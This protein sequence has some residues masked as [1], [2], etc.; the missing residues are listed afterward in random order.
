M[1]NLPNVSDAP[2]AAA[3]AAPSSNRFTGL[4]GLRAIAVVLVMVYHLFPGMLLGGFIGVDVFF[5]IS[6]FLITS[7]LV[8]ER[9]VRGRISLGRFWIRRA[10]RLVPALVTVVAVCTTIALVLGGDLL[11]GIGKQVLGA[12]TFSYNWIQIAAGSDYFT[13]DTPEL[14]RNFWSL[15][16]EEQFYIVWPFLLVVLMA[17]R[18]TW[19]RVVVVTAAAAGS[20]WWMLQLSLG[21]ADVT[22]MYYG[23]DSHA[24]GLLIGAALAFALARP[25]PGT[26]RP[27]IARSRVLRVVPPAIGLL[28]LAGVLILSGTLHEGDEATF[29]GGLALVSL[30]MVVVIWG[31]VQARSFLGRILDNAP[32]RYIGERSYGLY[33]WHWPLLVLTFA[34]MP[35]EGL[36]TPADYTVSGIIAALLTL[37]AAVLSYRFIEQPIRRNGFRATL[38]VAVGHLRRGPARAMGTAVAGLAAIALVATTTIAVAAAPTQTSAQDAIQRGEQA[39]A[40]GGDSTLPPA[41]PSPTPV[42]TSTDGTTPDPT[43]SP[44]PT[45]P[46]G[47][48]ITAIGDSVMLA[49]APELQT[50]FPGIYIDA[51]VSRSMFA[52]PDLLRTL[53]ASG[54]LRQTIVIGL[55]T[56]GP[57]RDATL[58]EI[59]EIA[60][61]DRFVVFVNAY[62]PRSWIDGVNATLDNSV[63]THE[64]AAVADWYD[65]VSPLA[66]QVLAGDKIHPGAKGGRLYAQTILS[67]FKDLIRA[68]RQR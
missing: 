8:R 42:P 58:S 5:V 1:S 44:A 38:R 17:V 16:V 14:F 19:L 45:L 11:V 46:T 56:N 39:L 36:P 31:A 6:G 60:G 68:Q 57:I 22:R 59:Y 52:A 15:A 53:D 67:S 21:G 20:A 54:Q 4:D 30:L 35:I 40:S 18:W 41:S 51:T 47:S 29:R 66:D 64:N 2:R 27:H 3:P 13:T 7:L 49:A 55:G 63:A 9:Q 37:L 24:F 48:E 61:P 32:M 12:A 50:L 26:G 62:A 34:W 23:T 33:L 10:R 43:P 28:A 25:S 65:A